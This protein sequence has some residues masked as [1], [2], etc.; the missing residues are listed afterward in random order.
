MGK[1]AW[2]D[3][4]VTKAMTAKIPLGK[5]CGKLDLFKYQMMQ[6]TFIII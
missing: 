2:G 1:K 3:P 6:C 4:A 5:F